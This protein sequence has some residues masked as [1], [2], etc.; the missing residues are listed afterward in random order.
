[1][2]SQ[3]WEY[4]YRAVALIPWDLIWSIYFILPV[5]EFQAVY[6]FHPT[7]KAK[8]KPSRWARLSGFIALFEF[9]LSRLSLNCIIHQDTVLVALVTL[10]IMGFGPK[11]ENWSN[12]IQG[13]KLGI[14]SCHLS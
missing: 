5:F 1:M 11:L 6:S 10:I 13:D 14:C 7:I 3:L 12:L 8:P 2:L 9:V 4:Q